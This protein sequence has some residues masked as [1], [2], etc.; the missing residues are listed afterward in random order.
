MWHQAVSVETALF[1]VQPP[2]MAKRRPVSNGILSREI[3]STQPVREISAKVG[4]GF[5]SELR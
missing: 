5:A 1:F 2:G 4:T 3:A